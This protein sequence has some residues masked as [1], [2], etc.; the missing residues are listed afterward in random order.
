[1]VIRAIRPE[2]KDALAEGFQRLSARS[3]YNR[4]FAPKQGLSVAELEYLT[5]LD[6]TRHVALLA[7][8]PK[9]DTERAV[10]VGRFIVDDRD[11]AS[12]EVA[13]TVDDEHH[14]LGIG[15]L[16]LTHLAAL[17]RDLGLSEFRAQVLGTNHQMLEVFDRCG[18]RMRRSMS[19]GEATV[20]L[21]LESPE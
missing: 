14:G 19:K 5:E 2:D 8:V 7:L 13:L 3:V 4:F 10:G 17:G 1:M 16:L 12:A 18:L 20:L 15:T 21:S 9:G 6:F 11:L